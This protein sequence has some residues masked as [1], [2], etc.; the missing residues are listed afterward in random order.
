MHD[1]TVREGPYHLPRLSVSLHSTLVQFSPFG[2]SNPPLLGLIPHSQK[3]TL[4]QTCGYIQISHSVL[5]SPTLDRLL[6]IILVRL[7]RVSLSQIR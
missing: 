1:G 5:I 2:S 3:L 4:V 6:L 7:N